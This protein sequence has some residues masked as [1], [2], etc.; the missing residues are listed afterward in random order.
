MV[1][2]AFGDTLTLEEIDSPLDG[3]GDGLHVAF[4]DDALQRCAVDWP[5]E[6]DLAYRAWRV[7][8]EHVGRALPLRARVNK[9]I[10]PG[11]GLG[12]GSSDAATMLVGLNAWAQLGL[13]REQLVELAMQLGSDVGFLVAAMDGSPT[14]IVSGLGETIEPV[15]RDAPLHLVL[16]LPPFGCATG[17]VY[18]AFDEHVGAAAALQADR[19][20]QLATTERVA[21][22]ELFNDLAEP[23]CVVQPELHVLRERVATLIHQPVHVTGSGAAMFAL[24]D[25]E[26]AAQRL[27]GEIRDNLD[28]PCIATRTLTDASIAHVLNNRPT[29][30]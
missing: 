7:M 25:D 27:A 18:R 21:A 29:A 4:A 6:K 5:L 17:A 28:L 8:E 13:S 9:R 30:T 1:A 10:P 23:A 16:M 19:V 26:A 15:T 12:G 2:V 14:A 11:A 3:A 24:V 20:R 22:D